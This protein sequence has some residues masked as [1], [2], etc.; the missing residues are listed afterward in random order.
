[1]FDTN[2]KQ[3]DEELQT[4]LA[5]ISA[6]L[7]FFQSGKC[8]IADAVFHWKDLHSRLF[9]CSNNSRIREVFKSKYSETLRDYHFVAYLLSP[10]YTANRVY[11]LTAEEEEMA[12]NY[13]EENFPLNF[14]EVFMRF[15]ACVSLFRLSFLNTQSTLTDAEWWKVMASMNPNLRSTH[16]LDCIMQLM[17]AVASSASLERIFSQFGIVHSKLGV[18]EANKLVSLFQKLNNTIKNALIWIKRVL[19]KKKSI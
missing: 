19:F 9:Y 6:S 4:L 5:P 8:K 16:S 3:L 2:I 7:N 10:K 15:R 17:T 18:M 11:A 12:M 13:I 1:M 14:V